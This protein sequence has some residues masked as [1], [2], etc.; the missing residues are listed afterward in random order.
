MELKEQ[1]AFLQNVC[2]LK[3]NKGALSGGGAILVSPGSKLHSVKISGVTGGGERG[4]VG[5]MRSCQEKAN[6]IRISVKASF[7]VDLAELKFSNFNFLSHVS[8]K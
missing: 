8:E 1:A 5:W 7:K 6:R 2:D 3:L 4:G